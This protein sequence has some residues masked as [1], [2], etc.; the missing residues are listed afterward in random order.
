MSLKLTT[1]SF[2]ITVLLISFSCTLTSPLERVQ[3]R[4]PT[5]VDVSNPISQVPSPRGSITQGL[6]PVIT[7]ENL[8]NCSMSRARISAVGTI[9]SADGTDW[10][11]PAENNFSASPKAADL[12]NECRQITYNSIQEIDLDSIPVVKIDPDGEII[13][14]YIFADNYFELYVN[15][16]LVAVD[17]V[18]FTPFNSSIVRFSVKRPITYA[19]KLIDWEENLGLG[20]ESNRGTDY[21]PGDGGF[22]ASFSDGTVT[23]ASWQAQTFYIA[24][25][26][27]PASVRDNG[28]VRDSSEANANSPSCDESCYA[29]HYPIPEDW[30]LEDFDDTAWPEAVTYSNETVGVDN[31]PSYTNFLDVFI[32]AEA[33]FIWSS[34]LVLDNLVLVRKT[35]E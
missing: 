19:V 34:N 13:T 26:E 12:Y 33:Q 30:F 8:L 10:I 21:H 14:G 6:A 3:D 32:G 35:V 15:G 20:T 28:S 24:P 17:P 29:L 7:I 22:V 18:P 23:D 27:S 5:T 11:V 1:L 9:T 16:K 31:K 25:L 4:L 2:A